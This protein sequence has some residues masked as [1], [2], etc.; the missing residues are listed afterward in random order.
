MTFDTQERKPVQPNHLINVPGPE[1]STDTPSSPWLRP[2]SIEGDVEFKQEHQNVPPLTK[3]E[4]EDEVLEAV[5]EGKAEDQTTQLQV[6]TQVEAVVEKVEK[7]QE[8]R[9]R[10]NRVL[11]NNLRKAD[12][13][14]NRTCALCLKRLPID[15]FP[16]LKR[17]EICEDCE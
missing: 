14:H 9:I 6:E 11:V 2:Q 8:Q 7:T 10:E 17:S 1:K 13:A 16:R 3:E 12:D 15:K 5:E 4:V